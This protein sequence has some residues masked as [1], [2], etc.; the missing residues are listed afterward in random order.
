MIRPGARHQDRLPPEQGQG[1]FI[2]YIKAALTAKDMSIGELA[3]RLD[4]KPSTVYNWLDDRAS[5]PGPPIV[6]QMADILDLDPIMLC[7]QL[8]FLPA[9]YYSEVQLIN[10]AT[11]ARSYLHCVQGMAGVLSELAQATLHI[12]QEEAK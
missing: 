8:G 3:R 9:R 5:Q 4:V 1:P 12:S 2:A 7:W 10:A 6:H 11:E